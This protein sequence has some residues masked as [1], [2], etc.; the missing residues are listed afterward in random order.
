MIVLGTISVSQLVRAQRIL[1]VPVKPLVLIV[2]AGG[3]LYHQANLSRFNFHLP[4]I[5]CN[6]PW[7]CFY[8]SNWSRVLVN[9]NFGESNWRP[10]VPVCDR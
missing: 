7:K 9:A 2:K 1:I 4:Y 10:I 6:L 5:L 8:A 3:R